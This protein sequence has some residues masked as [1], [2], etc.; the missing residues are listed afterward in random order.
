MQAQGKTVISDKITIIVITVTTTTIIIQ[1]I[2]ITIAMS[3]QT[4][5]SIL[6]Q[7]SI[8]IEQQRKNQVSTLGKVHLRILSKKA[9]LLRNQRRLIN[10]I[11]LKYRL[12]ENRRDSPTQLFSRGQV[13][14]RN[15]MI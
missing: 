3:I 5:R 4:A 1:I 15:L 11:K 13:L 8:K 14:Q 7:Y 6:T 2:S 10:S 9:F 12:N